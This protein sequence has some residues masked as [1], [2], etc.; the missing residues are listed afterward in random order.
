MNPKNPPQSPRKRG[1]DLVPSPNPPQSPRSRGEDLVPSPKSGRVRVG[2]KIFVQ[3]VY[4]FIEGAAKILLDMGMRRLGLV[5]ATS[6]LVDSE[7]TFS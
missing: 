4:C 2:F 3:E 7:I 6:L 1:E 5:V